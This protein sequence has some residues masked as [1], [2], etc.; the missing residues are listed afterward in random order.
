MPIN[1]SAQEAQ[2]FFDSFQI[3]PDSKTQK[4]KRGDRVTC[5]HDGRR[6]KAVINYTF[7][8]KFW[9][10]D[11]SKYD[12][13]DLESGYSYAWVPVENIYSY[14]SQRCPHCHKMCDP[15]CDVDY[16]RHIPTQDT[17]IKTIGSESYCSECHQYLSPANKW[18]E[19]KKAK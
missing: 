5:F 11:E 3:K 8:Q 15:L 7:R 18:L 12:V 10:E 6:F 17:E 9:G 13:T 16:I 4:W 1:M 2:S 19:G 14:D